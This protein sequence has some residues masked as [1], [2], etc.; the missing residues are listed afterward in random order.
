[1]L[2]VNVNVKKMFHFILCCHRTTCHVVTRARVWLPCH[3]ECRP[4]HREEPIFYVILFDVY[5][6]L[7][8]PP[9]VYVPGDRDQV[10]MLNDGKNKF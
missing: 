1:M 9:L 7:P 6:V 8:V 2:Y 3:H 4:W 5:R 10:L